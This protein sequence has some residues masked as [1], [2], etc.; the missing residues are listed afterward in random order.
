[1][2]IKFQVRAVDDGTLVGWTRTDREALFKARW[3][4]DNFRKDYQVIRLSDG[5]P[6]Y[7][8]YAAE[9]EGA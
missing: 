4:A 8:C 9:G 3:F 7:R 5:E 2:T 6:I 1:M